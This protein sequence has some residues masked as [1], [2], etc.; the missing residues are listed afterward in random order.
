MATQGTR[1]DKEEAYGNAQIY[2]EKIKVFHDQA[3]MHNSFTL[4]Q[5]VLLYS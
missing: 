1:R 4:G 3:F 5:K 2:N